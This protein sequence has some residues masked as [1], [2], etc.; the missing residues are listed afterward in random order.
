MSTG[1]RYDNEPKL[2][3]KKVFGVFIAFVVLILM[4]ILIIN[5]VTTSKD[6]VEIKKYFYFVSF[7]NG[8]FGVINNYGESVITPQYEELIAIPNN[9]KPI[10]VCTYDV[11]D[12]DGT[13]KTKV[14]NEK[15][16]EIFL[17]FDKV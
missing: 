8:K 13:Y 6:K 14:L 2:K 7:N 11:N 9:E 1:K 5:I 10:F 3:Y 12:I 16:E 4:I 17:G 15:N